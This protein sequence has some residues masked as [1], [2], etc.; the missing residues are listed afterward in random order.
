MSFL[1]RWGSAYHY[2]TIPSSEV[3]QPAT[4]IHSLHVRG[5]MSWLL[6]WRGGQ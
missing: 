1:Q 5:T 6:M 4:V 3:A 2:L